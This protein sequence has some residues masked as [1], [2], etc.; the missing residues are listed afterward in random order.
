LA[1]RSKFTEARRRRILEILAAGG[2]RRAAAAS[3]GVDHATLSRWLER[4]R[5]GAPGGAWRTFLEDVERAEGDPHLLALKRDYA[6]WEERPELALRFLERQEILE[7]PSEPE[8][9][10]IIHLNLSGREPPRSPGEGDD[11]D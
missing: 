6:L 7:P 5:R 1:A 8:G 11:D 3:A 2:S 9:P 10:V 4:G